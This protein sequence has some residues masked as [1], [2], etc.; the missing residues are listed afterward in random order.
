MKTSLL[1]SILALLLGAIGNG[2]G[3]MV[4]DRVWPDQM[5]YYPNQAAVLRVDLK[6]DSETGQEGTLVFELTGQLDQKEELA[7]EAVTVGPREKKTVELKWNTGQ[8]QYGQSALVT[9]FDKSGKMTI[10]KQEECFSISDNLWKVAQ[11][12]MVSHFQVV[13]KNFDDS[14]T[15]ERMKYTREGFANSRKYYANYYEFFSWAPDDFFELA[16]EGDNPEIWRTGTMAYLMSRRYARG[17]IQAAHDAGIRIVTYLQPFAMGRRTVEEFRKHPDWF[18]WDEFGQPGVSFTHKQLAEHRA[19]QVDL[20]APCVVAGSP[21]LANPKVIDAAIDQIVAAGKQYHFDGCRFDNTC[22]Q[23]VPGGYDFKGRPLVKDQAE[24]DQKTAYA[25]DRLR[26]RLEKELSP[27][28]AVGHNFAYVVRELNPVAWDR[29]AS[30]GWVIVDEMTNRLFAPKLVNPSTGGPR[31][32]MDFVRTLQAGRDGSWKL[33]GHY[34]MIG[35]DC[36]DIQTPNPK[37]PQR[38]SY[39]ASEA[40]RLYMNIFTFASGVHPYSY[41]YAP[42]NP[43]VGQ[44]WKFVTRYSAFLWDNTMKPIAKP[45]PMLAVNAN[46]N[47]WWKE[48]VYLR[49]VGPDRIQTIVH[50]VNPPLYPIHQNPKSELPPSIEAVQMQAAVPADCAFQR[51]VVLLPEPQIEMSELKAVKKGNQVVVTVPK[52]DLWGVVV[53]EWKPSSPKV[54]VNLI[55]A[56]AAKPLK[57]DETVKKAWIESTQVKVNTPLKWT[58]EAE[59]Y[60]NVAEK[61]ADPDAHN[62]FALRAKKG[63]SKEWYMAVGT[64]SSRERFGRYRFT[65]RVKCSDSTINRDVITIGTVVEGE[66][67]FPKEAVQTGLQGNYFAAPN[68]YEDF[69]VEV[70]RGDGGYLAYYMTYKGFADVSVDSITV[71]RIGDTTDKELEEVLGG[72]KAATQ[73]LAKSTPRALWVQGLFHEK[74]PFGGAL[75]ALKIPYQAVE[76]DHVQAG[77]VLRTFPKKWEEIS[78]YSLILL[79]N[80]DPRGLSFKGRA[81]IKSWVEQGGTLIVTG[82]PFSFGKGLTKGTMLDDI[83]PV[84]VTPRWD[85]APGGVFS[86]AKSSGGG[87]FRYSGDVGSPWIH[88]TMPRKGASVVLQAGDWPVLAWQKVGLGKVVVFMGTVLESDQPVKPFWSDPAWAKWSA[89]FLQAMLR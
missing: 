8:R 83:Y 35:M 37:D 59:A 87:G 21:N 50:L 7:R 66:N 52:L 23:V 63:V 9:V 5:V 27:H 36:D 74:D 40:T 22:Y 72:E 42:G 65:F 46:K 24:A 10:D 73:P 71:E 44:Y 68:K 1:L 25:L 54:F 51:A 13:P 79:S 47:V 70:L 18:I 26:E 3:A 28:F 75:D 86:F 34:Q 43:R 29:I 77:V 19:G 69:P 62:G 2:W 39:T 32:W 45:E 48:F 33:G 60:S 49:N 4:I 61:V 15:G 84:E 82:G 67:V 31:P 17:Y 64:Y 58:V 14:P 57:E 89:E 81:L 38:P 88:K 85:L 41:H 80:C 55:P 11:L 20:Y 78:A 30:K 6:N 53:F 12:S 56:A 16:P 76:V